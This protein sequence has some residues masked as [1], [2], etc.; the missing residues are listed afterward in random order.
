MNSVKYIIGAGM[1]KLSLQQKIY[2]VISVVVIV[3]VI[4]FGFFIFYV[5]KNEEAKLIQE[6]ARAS[7]LISQTILQS[8]YKDML[9]ERADMVYHLM[10]NVKNIK[11]MERVQIVRSNGVE[12]AFADDK[13]LKEVEEEYGEV[14]PEWK[15]PRIS[16]GAQNVADGVD[17]PKFKEAVQFFKDNPKSIEPIYFIEERRDKKLF[18]YLEIIRGRQKCSS[19]HKETVGFR[20]FFMLS[21]SL[22]DTYASLSKSRN[23]WI[24]FGAGTIVMVG[25]ILGTTITLGIIR[26]MK[27]TVSMLEDIAEI[28]GNLTKRLAVKTDDEIGRVA[29]W[30]NKFI[31]EM[32]EIITAVKAAFEKIFSIAGLL[33]VSSQ[34]MRQSAE[35]QLR[36]T[37]DTASAIN[38]V[39]SSMQSITDAA[40][41]IN[42]SMDTVSSSVLEMSTSSEEISSSMKKLASSTETTTSSITEISMSVK[43]AASSIETLSDIAER[44]ASSVTQIHANIK[45]IEQHTD[46]QTNLAENVKN[47]AT[48]AGVD[49]VKKTLTG[50]TRIREDVTLASAVIKRLGERSEAVGS[51]VNVIH[52]VA[53]TTSL[54]ALNAT[55]LAAKAGEHGRGFAVVANETKSLANKTATSTKEIAVIIQAFHDDIVNAINSIERSS[56]AVEEGVAASSEALTVLNKIGQSTD[57]TADMAKKIGVATKEQAQGVTLVT[58]TVHEMARM[59]EELKRLTNEQRLEAEGIVKASENIAAVTKT[60]VA[61]TQQQARESKHTAEIV[62]D[63][64]HKVK[65]IVKAIE[66]QR[67]AASRISKAMEMSKQ[68]GESNIT[69]AAELDNTIEEL[70]KQAEHVKEGMD[71][72]NV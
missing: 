32:Q 30:F 68:I 44:I 1:F 40:E 55:I 5:V 58:E 23:N 27:Q 24:L 48:S 64:A 19:C 59:V 26:P 25:F 39:D 29:L 12:A 47:Y 43:E 38:E 60:V 13:T 33:S 36:T 52:N 37:D 9:D 67:I 7:S 8:I 14:K 11:G 4:S 49:S 46:E 66:E 17:Y 65:A 41:H 34:K 16:R 54:L 10:K 42:S 18:T 6:K 35:Q 57:Q 22:E 15:T 3:L 50:M 61:S 20:A 45:Q 53:E 31:Q 69:L 62:S 72:F 2:L 63:V 56:T 28:K 70:N 21:I 51:I 71:K